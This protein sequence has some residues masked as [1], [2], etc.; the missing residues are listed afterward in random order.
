M[1]AHTRLFKAAVSLLALALLAAACSSDSPD[2]SDTNTD[3]SSTASSTASQEDTVIKIG[4]AYPDLAGL[5]VLNEEI[6]LGDFELQANAVLDR[7]RNDGEL[8]EGID[9]ELVFADYAIIGG[10]DKVAQC[11]KLVQDDEVLAVVGHVSF[12]PGAECLA[13]R[14]EVPVISADM[15]PADFYTRGTTTDF[16]TLQSDDVRYFR[17]YGKWVVETGLLDG[18]TIGLYFETPIQDGVDAFKEELAAGGYEVASEVSTSG[19]GIGS[20]EDV[21]AAQRFAVDGVD[22]IFPFVGPPS[23]TTVLTDLV[24]QEVEAIVFASDFGENINDIAA[25]TNPDEIYDGALGATMSRAGELG[26]GNPSEAME[27]CILNYEDFS[28]ESLP[29]SGRERGE[30]VS[31]QRSC[32]LLEIVLAGLRG[33]SE[34]DLTDVE[35]TQEAFKQGIEAAG[36]FDFTSG[37]SGSFTSS[38]HSGIDHLRVARWN[39]TDEV[40]EPEGEFFPIDG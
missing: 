20:P 31:I 18:K 21:V 27:N 9:V 10:E 6:A 32:D 29:R 7:W 33:L 24:N 1:R 26:S 23:V 13:Q 40:W 30:V 12:T 14:F 11:T 36:E 17:A 4:V 15:A 8:P 3:E 19:I 25:R 2:A 38:D 34:T 39:A 5:E 28:G 16:F 22:A 35:A 37:G